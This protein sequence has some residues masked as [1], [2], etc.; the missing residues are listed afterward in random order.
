MLVA[1]LMSGQQVL[2][3][4]QTGLPI[5]K[6]G[7]PQ[8]ID[9]TVQ[10]GHRFDPIGTDA[11]ATARIGNGSLKTK[12][13]VVIE[14]GSGYVTAPAVSF[15]GGSGSGASATAVIENGQVIRIDIDDSGGGYEKPPLVNIAAP[16]DEKGKQ[17]AAIAIIAAEVVGIDVVNGGQNY[18]AT[19]LPQIRISGAGGTGAQARAVVTS[20]AISGFTNVVGGELYEEAPT[21]EIVS[22]VRPVPER[23]SM[24]ELGF[25]PN[26]YQFVD[27]VIDMKLTLRINKHEDGRFRITAS[28]VDAAYAAG[29]NYNLNLASSV[30]TKIV[31]IPPP[32]MM[33]ERLRLLVEQRKAA[34]NLIKAE[35][36]STE[37]V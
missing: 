21:V 18:D 19:S 6:D 20:G 10:F 34:A 30:K 1:E 23:V 11:T 13:I 36:E 3:D 24:M 25:I 37:E 32:V 26:F 35:E 15:S 7:A 12:G 22:Q 31:P 16:A 33:E 28:S 8:M 4:P 2:R 29:Y 27:T 5:L 17:A 9:S 14:R